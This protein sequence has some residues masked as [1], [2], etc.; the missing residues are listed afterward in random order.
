MIGS[1]EN[2]PALV[3]KAVKTS[4]DDE[5]L[6]AGSSRT[7]RCKTTRTLKRVC[8]RVMICS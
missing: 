4:D 2:K 6:Y 3:H 8:S 5:A 1:V 7:F